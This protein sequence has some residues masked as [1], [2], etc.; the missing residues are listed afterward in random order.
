M[1]DNDTYPVSNINVSPY[2]M[3]KHIPSTSKYLSKANYYQYI[4]TDGREYATKW[5]PWFQ[6]PLMKYFAI[7]DGNF[8]RIQW[9]FCY[10]DCKCLV[11]IYINENI[12]KAI[13]FHLEK[14]PDV[15]SILYMDHNL[16]RKETQLNVSSDLCLLGIK[17]ETS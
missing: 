5:F 1:Y 6:H 14:F 13:F 8:S 4:A 16:F 12:W 17:G 7:E 9:P 3:G 10:V 11:F 15:I 2:P